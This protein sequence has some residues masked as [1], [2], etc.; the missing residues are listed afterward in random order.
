MFLLKQIFT[1]AKKKNNLHIII[2]FGTSF[3]HIF[4]KFIGDLQVVIYT[5]NTLIKQILMENTVKLMLK[6]FYIFFIYFF[7]LFIIEFYR[8]D[9]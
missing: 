4:D 5:K 3:T 7:F 8:I 9:L 6:Y 1:A 2:I